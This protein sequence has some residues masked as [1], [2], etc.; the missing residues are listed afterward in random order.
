MGRPHDTKAVDGFTPTQ[1]ARRFDAEFH[2][3]VVPPYNPQE[4]KPSYLKANNRFE[5]RQP[6]TAKKGGW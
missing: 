3:H 1:H 2:S 6:R 4:S 5:E